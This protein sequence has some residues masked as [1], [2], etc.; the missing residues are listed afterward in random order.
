[1]CVQGYDVTLSY[2]DLLIGESII[3]K[4]IVVAATGS[5]TAKRLCELSVCHSNY[6]VTLIAFGN[7][8]MSEPS[9]P[10]MPEVILQGM[11]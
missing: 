7:S 8:I 11:F 1:M 2:A 4:T 6:T 9:L 5:T 10:V 3:N